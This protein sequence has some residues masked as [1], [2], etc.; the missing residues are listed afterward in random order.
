MTLL[1]VD[2]LL[3]PL[4][5][6][7]PCGANLEY[8]AAFVALQD[9]ARGRAEQQFGGTIIAAVEPDWRELH[10]QA[11]A[12]AQRTRDLR[13]AVLLARAAARQHGLRAYADALALI[14]GLL[15]TQWSGVYPQ[16]EGD[17]EQDP[18]MRL[19]ALGPLAAEDVGLTDLRTASIVD[20]PTILTVRHVELAFGKAQALHDESLPTQEGV[21]KALNAGQTPDADL[22][23]LLRQPKADLRRIELVI[24]DKCGA[25]PGPDLRPLR[26]LLEALAR[27]AD[28]MLGLAA[29][30][31]E[32]SRAAG[33]AGATPVTAS[34]SSNQIGNRGDV[35]RTLDRACD[36]IEQHEPTNPAPL[37]IRRAQRLMNKNFLEI[38]RDLVP[39]GVDQVERIA[40]SP[41]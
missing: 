31:N 40:G 4:S 9:A 6:E 36:W 39:E 19:N 10:E 34:A 29:A 15:E 26:A 33:A 24:T 38:I 5:D 12:L 8:D 32:A 18:T 30:P 13:V 16:L 25:A 3:A 35:L 7:A 22:P 21:L 41:H 28:A 17:A 37:L 23:A 27:A 20:N 2:E 14:A 1:P 11:V